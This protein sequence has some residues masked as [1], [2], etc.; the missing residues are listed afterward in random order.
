M[1][2]PMIRQRSAKLVLND[3]LLTALYEAERTGAAKVATVN[4]ILHAIADSPEIKVIR[5]A[6]RYP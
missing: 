5:K 1:T 3:I 2:A 6:G 4:A